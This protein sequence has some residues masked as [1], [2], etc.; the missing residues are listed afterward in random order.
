VFVK[1][2]EHDDWYKFTLATSSALTVDILKL[3]SDVTARFTL[4]N[5]SV[6]AI[7]GA[8]WVQPEGET[9]GSLVL[10]TLPAGDYDLSVTTDDFAAGSESSKNDEPV[11]DHFVTPYRF[12][13]NIPSVPSN[14]VCYLPTAA[15]GAISGGFADGGRWQSNESGD[16]R[17]EH[18]ETP[19][20]FRLAVP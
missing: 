2:D 9:S 16:P 15:E 4:H 7:P 5:A 11:P 8:E 6:N 12:Q 14:G 17:P 18:F 19:Y 3:P 10:P 1:D 20:Q 13:L